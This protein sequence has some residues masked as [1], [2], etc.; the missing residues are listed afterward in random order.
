MVP[1]LVRPS[2]LF[3]L[4]WVFSAL[5]PALWRF[6]QLDAEENKLF[7]VVDVLL[8][9]LFYF[10]LG[11]A[12]VESPLAIALLLADSFEAIDAPLGEF[13][14]FFLVFDSLL[15]KKNLYEVDVFWGL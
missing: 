6:F 9:A 1:L 3:S 13:V 8:E 5:E 12:F 14:V 4:F 11:L 7:D 2:S 10:E 15:L